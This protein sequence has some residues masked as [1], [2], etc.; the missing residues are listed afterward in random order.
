[1]CTNILNESIISVCDVIFQ[2]GSNSL[3]DFW[4]GTW[5]HVG[6]QL[7]SM[8][9]QVGLKLASCWLKLAQV[10]LMLAQVGPNWLQVASMLPQIGLKVV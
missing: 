3:P 1:M 6:S 7:G 8:L 4:T 9:A 5:P 2:F 10:G